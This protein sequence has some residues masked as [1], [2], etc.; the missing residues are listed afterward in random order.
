MRILRII[1]LFIV[2]GN[3]A[4]NTCYGQ[5]RKAR[6]PN[7][8]KYD[9][10]KKHFGFYLGFNQM[11]F[12]I[13][14][15]EGFQ[16]DTYTGEQIRDLIA[17]SAR[18]NAIAPAAGLGFTIGMVS[19]L[20]I[21]KYFDLRFVPGLQFASRDI[22]YSLMQFRN[23]DTTYFNVIK[24]V[25]TT[26]VDFPLRIK[27]KAMRQW[28][29]R[30][31]LFTGMTFKIDLASSANEKE[32]SREDLKVKM[33]R[34]DYGFDFG[35]GFDVYTVW[36]KFAMQIQMTYGLRDILFREDNIYSSSI[37]SIHSK[38]FQISFTFE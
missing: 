5:Y 20:R 10:A 32:E 4:I 31:Y 18:V 2:F 7:L 38:M 21:G 28:N 34:F 24:Q 14:P 30:A 37:G 13:N 35:A 15:Q 29:F 36:F 23:S 1:L 19:N 11:N 33:N 12:T 3:A 26:Y 17:D 9:R 16:Y 6:V 8:P 22:K 25:P 27:F